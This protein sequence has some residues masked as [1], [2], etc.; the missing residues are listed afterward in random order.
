M[1]YYAQRESRCRT[2]ERD[3][4]ESS[5]IIGLSTVDLPCLEA[6]LMSFGVDGHFLSVPM[7]S[8]FDVGVWSM[9]VYLLQLK[10][11]RT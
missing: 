7:D 2:V 5:L 11:N 6:H 10:K 1:S 4:P 8:E 3:R 9:P